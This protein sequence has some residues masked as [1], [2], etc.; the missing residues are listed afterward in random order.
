[1]GWEAGS[2]YRTKNKEQGRDKEKITDRLGSHS[3]FVWSQEAQSWL[4][5]WGKADHLSCVSSQVEQCRD[6]E[7]I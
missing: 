3:H 2:F 5:V 4:G 6:M 1:M 7:V